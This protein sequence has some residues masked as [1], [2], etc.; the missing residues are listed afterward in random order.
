MIGN[1]SDEIRSLS[2]S[3]NKE[4][5]VIFSSAEIEKMANDEDYA[6]EKMHAV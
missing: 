2:K 5:S 3:G 1:G 4:F 6:A